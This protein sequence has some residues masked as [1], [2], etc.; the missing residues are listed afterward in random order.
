MDSFLLI[1]EKALKHLPWLFDLFYKKRIN[2]E[3]YFRDS[4]ENPNIIFCV[5]ISVTDPPPF[6]FASIGTF[7]NTRHTW[8]KIINM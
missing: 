7:I 3:S 6:C 2:N 8:K 4:I 1:T 5:H